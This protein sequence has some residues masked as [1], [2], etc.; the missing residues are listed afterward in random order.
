MTFRRPSSNFNPASQPASRGVRI[1]KQT[2]ADFYSQPTARR[3]ATM[4]VALL[5]LAVGSQAFGQAS[6]PRALEAVKSAV[7][8]Q[9]EADRVDHSN[10]IYREQEANLTYTCVGSPQGELR[11]LIMRDGKPV[12]Q[13]EAQQESQQIANFVHDP[14]EQARAHKN[15]V[16]DDEQATELLKMLPQAFLW[17]IAAQ[18]GDVMTLNYRPNPSFD[19]P[20]MES[21]VMSTMAGQMVVT[22]K[23]NQYRIQ[24]F[25]GAL[26][27]DF[28]IAFG[29]IAKLYKGG[30]FDVERREVARGFW[31]ITDTRVHI[32]GHALFFKTIGTQQDE[33][34]TDWKPSPAK[35]LVEAAR[36][37]G[38]NP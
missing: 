7:A 16:H 32:A 25:R 38:V 31:E 23:G 13:A 27:D 17:T 12:S 35:N 24:T 10:W 6:D 30:T 5:T 26:T 3:M 18:N 28:K 14:A 33:I 36:L 2:M 1:Q 22:R 20:D 15:A 34:K 19:G 29:V 4:A 11:R 9:L 37:L 8:S 21:K